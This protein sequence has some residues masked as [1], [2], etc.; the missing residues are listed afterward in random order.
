M[1]PAPQTHPIL[2]YVLAR[3]PT[4]S[5]LKP[6]AAASD[7]DIEQPPVHTPSPRTPSTAGEFELVE[8]MPG[9]RHPSVL[10]AMTRAVADVSAARAALEVLGPRPDHELVDSSRA[11]IA[12]AE[13]GD[14]E[15]PEGDLQ[16]CRAV[17]R[18][19]ETHDAYE[20]LLQ[21]A[22]GRLEKVYRSAMEG[23]DLDDEAEGKGKE[24]GLA[25]GGAEGGDAAVQEEVVAVLKQAEEGKTV[26][27]V[28]LVDRQLRQLPE[29]FG[30]IQGVRVLDVS[31]NQLEVIPDAIGGLDQLEELRLSTNALVSL[32]DSIGLLS[33]L[34][35][36]NV[37]NNRLRALP[38]SISKCRSLVELDASYNNLTY[39]PTNIGYELVNL[40]KLRVHMNKLRSLPSS[41]CEMTSLY[42]LDAHFNEL[43]GLPSAFGKLSSL[44]ILDLSSNFSDLKELPASFGDLLNLRELYLSNNQIHAL[45]DSFGRLDKLERLNLE[46]NPLGMPPSDIVNKGVDAVK[47]YM[48]KRWLDILLEEEQKRIAAE[49]PQASSTPKAWLDRSVSWVSGVSGSLVGYLSGNEKSEKDAYLNQQF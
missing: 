25:A 11:I 31:R 37:A 12:A 30:R 29:A 3:I 19:E 22:E 6:T 20:A 1:D 45:P 36:L 13:A 32:P 14:S 5:K 43:C 2:S 4:L 48:S 15:V 47:E 17:V 10:R 39:L 46:Q 21:D 49:T 23:T 41:V 26:E 35:I 7:F 44:E 28:R 8:R 27:S 34:K 18:L 9:L 40:Q 24:D 16:G 33:N 42:L 38:D